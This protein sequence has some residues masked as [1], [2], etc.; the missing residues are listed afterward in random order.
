MLKIIIPFQDEIPPEVSKLATVLHNLRTNNL[1]IEIP[2]IIDLQLIHINGLFT[3][4]GNELK[5][6]SLEARNHCT[7]INS[8][9]KLADLKKLADEE[10]IYEEA[11]HLWINEIG[12]AD[13]ASGRFL[14]LISQHFNVLQAGVTVVKNS[15]A[16]DVFDVLRNIG[17]ALPFLVDFELTDLIDLAEAQHQKTLGDMAAGLFFNQVGQYLKERPQRAIE[18]YKLICEKLS[19]SNK[20]LYGSALIGLADAGH[21]QDATEFAIADIES[22]NAELVA[23][24]LWV[25]GR[26]SLLW[27]KDSYL[28]IRIQKILN[29]MIKHGDENVSRQAYQALSNAAASQPELI[30]ELLVHAKPDNQAAL[31]ILGNFVFFNFGKIIHHPSF[32]EILLALTDLDV[33]ST[34]DLDYALSKL[35]ETAKFDSLVSDCLTEWILKNYVHRSLDDKLG[36]CFTQTLSEIA[37]KPLLNEL[38]TRWLV[39]DEMIL[40]RAYSDLIGYLWVHGVRKPIF[41]KPIL[42]T[43]SATDLKYLARRL[44]GW[45]FH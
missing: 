26:L 16:S 9:R 11:H 45:T 32:S 40:G 3:V 23:V 38:L 12:H 42:D 14:G 29:E 25:I 6:G 8:F 13:F 19:V 22:D 4:N 34:H 37:N 20:N 28:K 35:I 15:T 31:Q 18:L 41:F 10:T 39:S 33:K 5:F 27:E 17:N 30:I 2:K 44:L 21:I 24:A 7:A 43:L 36:S 1:S